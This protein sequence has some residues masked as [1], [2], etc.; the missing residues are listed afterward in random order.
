MTNRLVLVTG[1]NGFVG[2]ALCDH[3]A[4]GG[5]RVRGAFRQR[6]GSASA[7]V[8]TRMIGEICETTDWSGLLAGV[9]SVVHA[10][11]RVH[12]VNETAADPLAAFRRVNVAG[13]VRLACQAAASGVKRMVFLSSIGAALAEHAS[14]AGPSATPYQLSKLEAERALTRIARETGLELVIVR[15]PLVYG[16]GARGNFL[17]L[18]RIVDRGIPLPLASIRNRRSFIGLSNI[19]HLLRL[20]LERP[21]AAGQTFVVADETL[22]TPE[23]IRRIAH[24][25]GRP[26]RLFPC[27]SGLLRLAGLLSGQRAAIAG[28]VESL[29]L[30][31][32]NAQHALDWLPVVSM[33]EELARAAAWWR[34]GEHT[35][36]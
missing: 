28:L 1:A 12:V 11:A 14:P 17:R 22:S 29:E 4:T 21:E 36:P 32:G 13:S 31:A 18:M 23:L 6:C 5:Y 2:S 20:C 24:A 26:H 30:D 15:P 27:P 8:E 34:D 10:A 16:P 9:D 33:E 19:C 25:L 3:L 35:A 7:D